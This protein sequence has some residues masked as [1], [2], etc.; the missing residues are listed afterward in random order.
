MPACRC[1]P[2]GGYL[3]VAAGAH[4]ARWDATKLSFTY[5]GSWPGP[6][7]L[8][9]RFVAGNLPFEGAPWQEFRVRREGRLVAVSRSSQHGQAAVSRRP[10]VALAPPLQRRRPLT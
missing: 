2:S 4:I 7:K 1:L 3:L 9:F 6:A 5:D 8:R 10:T